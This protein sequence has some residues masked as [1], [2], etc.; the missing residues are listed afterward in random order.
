MTNSQNDELSASLEK[1]FLE[2]ALKDQQTSTDASHDIHHARRVKQNAHY[3]YRC[4][5][6]ARYY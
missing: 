4:G 2:H 3:S 1:A 6:F 5:V